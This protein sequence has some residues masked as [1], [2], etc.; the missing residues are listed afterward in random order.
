[1]YVYMYLRRYLL[2]MHSTTVFGYPFFCTACCTSYRIWVPIF[3][4]SLFFFVTAVVFGVD[5]D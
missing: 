1:M 3:L 4:Y 2:G 5:D